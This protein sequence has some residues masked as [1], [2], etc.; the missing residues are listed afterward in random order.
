MAL[1]VVGEIGA[2]LGLAHDEFVLG[3]AGVADVADAGEQRPK[4]SRLRT[5]PESDVPP[6][7]TP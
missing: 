7:L 2:G 4:L 3:R 1:Q 6:K 5:M